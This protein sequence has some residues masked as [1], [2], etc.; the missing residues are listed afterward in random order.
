MF[1]ILPSFSNWVLYNLDKVGAHDVS[2]LMLGVEFS[3]PT[4]AGLAYA[5]GACIHNYTT[6]KGE[7]RSRATPC[8]SDVGGIFD[9]TFSTA[10]EILHK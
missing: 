9:G 2:P 3:D 1:V 8:C 6:Q 4:I 10:H 7:N 5:G